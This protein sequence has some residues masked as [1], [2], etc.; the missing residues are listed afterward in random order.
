MSPKPPPPLTQSPP[1]ITPKTHLFSLPHNPTITITITITTPPPPPPPSS[2]PLI[3]ASSS[4]DPLSQKPLSQTLKSL[5]KLTLP[6]IASTATATLFFIRFNPKSL[7]VPTTTQPQPQPQ[8]QQPNGVITCSDLKVKLKVVD[9]L[10]ELKP[11]DQAWNLLKTQIRNYS[12]EL[13]SARF[14]FREILDKDLL[15][16]K[17]HCEDIRE[18]LE[19]VDELKDLSL[20]IEAAMDNCIRNSDIKLYLR[21]FKYL[22]ARVR[23]S[24][25]KVFGALKYFQELEQ[26]GHNYRD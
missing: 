13:D 8:Q 9:Y 5:L 17:P 4:P 21:D 24:K 12:L 19:M 1:P 20:E 6:T 3:R 7:L 26:R 16:H 23:D 22:V 2:S 11:D 25:R 14:G 10:I 18:C 15:C